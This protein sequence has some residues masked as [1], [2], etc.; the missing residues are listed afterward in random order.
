MSLADLEAELRTAGFTVARRTD[1]NG[2]LIVEEVGSTDDDPDYDAYHV[3]VLTAPG[4]PQSLARSVYQHLYASTRWSPDPIR[5]GPANPPGT[6]PK[7][8]PHSV[9]TIPV[10]DG[11]FDSV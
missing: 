9:L 8:T 6:D 4:H 10:D 3:H 5:P 7:S 1:T 2:S 11:Y